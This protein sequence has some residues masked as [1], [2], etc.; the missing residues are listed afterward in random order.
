MIV[1][2]HNSLVVFYRAAARQRPDCKGE[3]KHALEQR[4]AFSKHYAVVVSR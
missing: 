4:L 1:S 2:P 3:K